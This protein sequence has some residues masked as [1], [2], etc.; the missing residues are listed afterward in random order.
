M[1]LLTQTRPAVEP[2]IEPLVIGLIETNTMNL[3]IGFCEKFKALSPES[4]ELFGDAIEVMKEP[5]FK[6][7]PLEHVLE[8]CLERRAQ[9]LQPLITR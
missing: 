3:F 4:Q 7:A 2:K 6:S 8:V 9:Q 1:E 5:A